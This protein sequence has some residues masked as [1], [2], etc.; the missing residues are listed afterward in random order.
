MILADQPELMALASLAAVPASK[1]AA[2]FNDPQN[3]YEHVDL[4]EVERLTGAVQRL[5]AL[6][7]QLA[8]AAAEFT[9]HAQ[10]VASEDA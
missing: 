6:S 5:N 1:L 4:G 3:F 2:A 9:E 10:A 8:E 7:Q